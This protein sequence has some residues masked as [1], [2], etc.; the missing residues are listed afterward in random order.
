MGKRGP[1]PKREKAI[2]SKDYQFLAFI[3]S[4]IIQILVAL[5]PDERT[6]QIEQW[7]ELAKEQAK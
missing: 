6:K 3:R 7:Y 5:S 1:Q 2:T 4:E